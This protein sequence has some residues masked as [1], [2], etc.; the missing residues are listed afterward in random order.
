MPPPEVGCE[1]IDN[2]G[3][4]IA[5]IELGWPDK[6]MGVYIEDAPSVRGWRFFSLQQSVEYPEFV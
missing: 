3:R 4:V 2:A 1:I 5:E 6:K